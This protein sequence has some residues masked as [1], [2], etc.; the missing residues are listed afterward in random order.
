MSPHSDYFG[1]FSL[2]SG[3]LYNL[4]TMKKS[5]IIVLI[6]GIAGVVASLR[7]PQGATQKS[8]VQNSPTQS[9]QTPVGTSFTTADVGQHST[10]QSC[11]T[12]VNGS[13]Y[14]LTSYINQHPG[15][16]DQIL[17]ICGGDGSSLFASQH[18][19]Q[20]GPM[21]QLERLKMGT[22]K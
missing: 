17:S 18:G 1:T 3:F 14:D 5:I 4:L 12:M 16:P 6:I 20:G 7:I 13:V 2:F 21:G 9:A 15:G 11:W 8:Q 10:D 19:G 22:V